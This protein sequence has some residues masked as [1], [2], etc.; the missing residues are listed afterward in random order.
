MD[1]GGERL[2]RS[3]ARCGCVSEMRQNDE[4]TQCVSRPKLSVAL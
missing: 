1:H 4:V 3:G 2:E